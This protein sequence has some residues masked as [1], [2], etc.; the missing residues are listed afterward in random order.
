M[1]RCSFEQY[2]EI[3]NSIHE[4]EIKCRELL[5]S[6]SIHLPKHT[7]HPL[8]KVLDNLSVFKSLAEDRMFKEYPN[9]ADISIFYGRGK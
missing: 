2:K 8:S 4:L 5:N 7:T 6:S 9:D 3:A 1:K